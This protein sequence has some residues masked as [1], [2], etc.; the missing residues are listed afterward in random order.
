MCDIVVSVDE[1]GVWF[2]K[3]SDREPSEAHGV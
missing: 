2:A 3:N 1:T